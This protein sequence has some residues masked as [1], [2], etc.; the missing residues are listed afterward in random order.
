[1]PKGTE[2]LSSVHTYS[3]SLNSIKNNFNN[4]MRESDHFKN[5]F[6]WKKEISLFS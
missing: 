3:F 2:A 1:M 5:D 4:C 6:L